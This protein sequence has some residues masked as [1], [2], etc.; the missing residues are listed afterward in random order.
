[1][2]LK[3]FAVID[4][5]VIVSTGISK[6]GSPA[7]VLQLVEE[8]NII[9]V[10]DERMLD[11]YYKVLNYP[12][13]AERISQPDVYDLLY[14]VVKNGLLINDVE[15]A[16]GEF[17]DIDDIPFFEVKESSKE[18]DSYLVTGNKKHFPETNDIVT[19]REMLIVM[20]NNDK[21]LAH[22]EKFF[23]HNDDYESSVNKLI[24]AKIC[25][26]KYTKG[27][28]IVSKIFDTKSKAIKKSYFERD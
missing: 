10:F 26:S 5:N 23:V 11:E 2:R 1:M 21:L 13:I 6:N 28:E 16:K 7:K 14:R 12:H 27:S 17:K 18:F 25:S 24:Q 22:V 9:P 19:S 15:Q 20:E 8:G 3:A 4:T